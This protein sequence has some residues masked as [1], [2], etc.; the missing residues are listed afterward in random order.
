[1]S[2]QLWWIVTGAG[3]AGLMLAAAWQDVRTRRIPNAL[4]MAGLGLALALRV[5]FGFPA[6]AHGLEGA[7]LA[8][9]AALLLF[10]L[11]ALGGGDAKL[12]VAMGA[13]MGP[14]GLLGAL[15]VVFLCGLALAVVWTAR[16]GLF[17]LLLVNTLDL[18]KSG[19]FLGGAGRR[20]A[21]AGDQALT[22]PYGVSI[23]AGSL[24]W[25]F[26]QG[27]RP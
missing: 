5:P 12:L 10:A 20:Q 19:K 1:L 14:D 13:F 8:F 23:A 11:G 17:P 15:A 2:H 16:K 4:S 22:V 24:L 3:L 26:G 18:V 21:L 27:V 9:G 6:L 7:A 25:W